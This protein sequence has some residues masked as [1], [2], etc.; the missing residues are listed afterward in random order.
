MTLLKAIMAGTLAMW[1]EINSETP[2]YTSMGSFAPSGQLNFEIRDYAPSVAAETC[3]EGRGAFRYLAGYIGV[4][5][6]PK[7]SAGEKIAMTAPV[8]GYQNQ[9]GEECMQFILP[10][11]EFAGDVSSAPTPT[12]DHVALKGRPE[13][14]MAVYKFSGRPSQSDFQEKLEK[15]VAAI[16]QMDQEAEDFEWAI[17]DPSHK[18]EYQYNPP[19]TPGKWRTNEV[20]IELVKKN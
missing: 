15:L 20:A 14:F 7:N 16:Q 11:S 12:D 8:V 19:W 5:S 1:G 2:A 17:K 6:K 3:N 10:E 4:M 18:E 9:A 13:M